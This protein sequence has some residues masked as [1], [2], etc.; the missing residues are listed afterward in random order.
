LAGIDEVV[1]VVWTVDT[2]GGVLKGVVSVVHGS[3]VEA[4]GGGGG[5]ID[6]V[7]FT[8]G[9]GGGNGDVV[10]TGG[11]S[12]GNEDVVCT[13]G[14]IFFVGGGLGLPYSSQSSL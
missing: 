9:G 7:V 10:C 3:D 6:V 2:A 8:G 11:G 14:G 1:L 4:G 5:G 13:G 12:G